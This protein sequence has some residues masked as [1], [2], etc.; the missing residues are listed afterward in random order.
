MMRCFEIEYKVTNSR[1]CRR[2]TSVHRNAAL[3]LS[4]GDFWDLAMSLI[5]IVSDIVY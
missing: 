1:F 5:A 4:I 3:I 2:S